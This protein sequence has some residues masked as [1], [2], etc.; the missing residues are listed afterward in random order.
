MSALLT[1]SDSL[2]ATSLP[3]SGP[4]VMP[5][6]E[7]D[8]RTVDR[9][10]VDQHLANLSARQAKAAGLM[11]SGT[12]GR[13]STIS[14]GSADL[15]SSWASRLRARTDLLGS[16][17]FKLTWKERSTPSGRSIAALR[18]SALRTSDNDSGGLRNDLVSWP[19][20]HAN[21]TTGAGTAGRDGGLN[22]QTAAQL[23]S[24][25]TAAARDWKGATKERWGE[26]ARPLNEVAVLAGWPTCLHADSRGSAGVGK[27]ELPNIAQLAGW[28][29]QVSTEIGNTLEN[30]SA[31]K[32]NMKSGPRTAITHPSL[33]A[34]LA[35]W[36]T[37]MAGTPAQ[38]GYNEAGNTDSSRQTV[39]L[40]MD[41]PGGPA[42]LTAFGEILIGSSAE[43]ESGGQLD[44]AH[45]FWLMGLPPEFLNCAPEATRSSRNSRKRSSK[46]TSISSLDLYRQALGLI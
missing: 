26:N 39:S 15:Q 40:M 20:P 5:F 8:G 34:Q 19:T 10:G 30:Y 22:I 42:R 24:W 32:A 7:Q 38:K 37:P 31:M 18:A 2:N 43:M 13:R 44:P 4:G 9:S 16:T 23:T 12:Y 21:S 28:A 35:S 33:Q 46:A 25:P 3:G 11:T 14:S 41:V 27:T 29:T 6:D 36:P 1:L 45:T 17:L